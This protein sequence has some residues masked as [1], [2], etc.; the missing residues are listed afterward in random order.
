MRRF[1]LN[2]FVP[3]YT[4]NYRAKLLHHES[5]LLVILIFFFGAF[6]LNY[7]SKTFPS[8]LGISSD[9]TV[10]DL[11]NLTN[12]KRT[13]N[14]L[15][16]LSINQRLSNAASSKA[17]NMFTENY[18]AHISPGGTTPWSFIRSAGYSYVYAGE[19]LAKGFTNSQDVVNAWM[20]SPS[21]RKNVLS[22]N[23]NNVGFSIQTGNLVG[24]ETVLIVQMFGSSSE[25]Q[26]PPAIS[27]E[28]EKPVEVKKVAAAI[29]LQT[30]QPVQEPEKQ[31]SKPAFLTQTKVQNQVKNTPAIKGNLV[32]GSAKI[33]PAINSGLL[34]KNLAL[35]A[36]SSF[37]FI[38]T[39]DLILVKRKR[40][41]RAVGH[42][43]D[44]IL[45]FVL[46]ILLISIFTR[47]VII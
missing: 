22:G 41:A 31:A 36:I 35:I 42:N 7:T 27:L 12:Q 4:N 13:E 37:I 5:L 30:D 29:P 21:H 44:H 19:N 46:M 10:S 17:R 26:T 1:F 20:A 39:M 24:E 14:G 9:I 6:T 11:L 43:I 45:F 32:M 47:G 38:L 28:E 40:I 18:W 34:T 3:H 33:P 25:S 15:P 16:P 2:L 8:V 23:Y